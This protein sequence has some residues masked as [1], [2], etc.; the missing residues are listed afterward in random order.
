MGFYGRPDRVAGL[1][2][3]MQASLLLVAAGQDRTPVAE[4]EAFA[5]QVR[6]AG[7]DAEVHVYP[8][9]PHGFFDRAY[10]QYGDERE[11]AWRR[12]VDFAERRG[13]A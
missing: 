13:R 5:A 8:D 7:V 4:V 11:D 3:R 10:E 6:E 9:A 1:V 2:E 12:I